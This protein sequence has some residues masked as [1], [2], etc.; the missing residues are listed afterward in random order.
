MTIIKLSDLENS[1]F[2][3]CDYKNRQVSTYG[4]RFDPDYKKLIGI[5][6]AEDDITWADAIGEYV[7]VPDK[8]AEW[9]R[10]LLG[11]HGT[12]WLKAHE[13]A[14]EEQGSGLCDQEGTTA[15]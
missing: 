3:W 5:T 11:P 7:S 15:G 14:N 10:I 8:C 1:Y 4:L 2:V 12:V 13:I 6:D 9:V